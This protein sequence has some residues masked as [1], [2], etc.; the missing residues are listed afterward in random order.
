MAYICLK[1]K[2]AMKKITQSISKTLLIALTFYS[3]TSYSMIFPT[4]KREIEKESI[5]DTVN[6]ITTEKR[7]YSYP[8]ISANGFLGTYVEALVYNKNG[9]ILSKTQTKLDIPYLGC[10]VIHVIST[11]RTLFNLRGEITK[12]YISKKLSE[13]MYLM[14]DKKITYTDSGEKIRQNNL[15]MKHSVQGYK[16]PSKLKVYFYNRRKK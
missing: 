2:K 10:N 5:V 16:S 8:T 14:K 3:L 13:G 1:I 11:K 4:I 15:K 12:I 7:V 6:N 9:K